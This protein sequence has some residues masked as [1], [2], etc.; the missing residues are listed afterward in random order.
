MDS[1]VVLLLAVVVASLALA[2][3][4]VLDPVDRVEDLEIPL[5]PE[6]VEALKIL[7]MQSANR[8]LV[9]AR[10]LFALELDRLQT[11]GEKVTP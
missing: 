11:L 3:L 7:K 2:V 9:E 1:V 4:V 8:L 10:H 6:E 5:T